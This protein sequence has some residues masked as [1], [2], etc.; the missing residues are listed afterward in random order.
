MSRPCAE[1]M[2]A[3]RKKVEFYCG[4]AKTMRMCLIDGLKKVNSWSLLGE[5]RRKRS[6]LNLDVFADSSWGDCHSSRR[7]TSSSTIFL[8]GAYVLIFSRTQATVAVGSCEAELCAA[9]AAI[10]EG[11]FLGRLC[12]FLVA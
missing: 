4:D 9:N 8:N 5:D 12:E 7:S 2:S 1:A 10:S 6:I 3:V 11:L